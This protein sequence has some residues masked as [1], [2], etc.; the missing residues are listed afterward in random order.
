MKNAFFSPN[1]LNLIKIPSFALSFIL[2]EI[3]ILKVTRKITKARNSDKQQNSQ[4]NLRNKNLGKEEWNLMEKIQIYNK[5][6]HRAKGT[7]LE[8]KGTQIHSKGTNPFS[9]SD[10]FQIHSSST[11]FTAPALSALCV[12]K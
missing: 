12:V 9:V 11:H 7:N 1:F 10:P 8:K 3:I 6:G 2:C 4:L 5:F